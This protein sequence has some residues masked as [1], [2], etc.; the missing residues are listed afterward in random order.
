MNQQLKKNTQFKLSG[1]HIFASNVDEMHSSSAKISSLWGSMSEVMSRFISKSKKLLGKVYT[2]YVD[3]GFDAISQFE[4]L[5]R[6]RAN[7]ARS[8]NE[9]MIGVNVGT[10]HL[11]L[12]TASAIQ[13][14]MTE[15]WGGGYCFNNLINCAETTFIQNCKQCLAMA[16]H[17]S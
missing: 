6:L 5:A 7:A 16:S 15:Y 3:D 2:V 14:P 1:I 9:Y 12:S 11:V 8:I 4:I 17:R 13:H 10:T